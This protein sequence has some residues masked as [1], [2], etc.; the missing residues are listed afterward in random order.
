MNQ[1]QTFENELFKVFVKSENGQ[2]TFDVEQV[3][4]SLGLTQ[5][6]NGRQYIRWERVNEYLPQNSPLVGKGDF[7]PE[8]LV[9]KLAFKASNDV[10]EK[11][12]DWLAIEVI[13]SIRKHG[14]YATPETIENIISDPEFG[15]K[16]LTN[17]KDEKD[18]RLKAEQTIELQKPKVIYAEAVSVSNDTVLIKDL[19]TVLKQKGFDIG[20]NRLFDWLRDNGY[21]CKKK[22]ELW[23][24][25]TQRS[26]DL[27][28]MVTKHGLRTGSD[29][30]M[31][32]TR[33]PKIT[34]KGQIYFI[35]KF[36]NQQAVI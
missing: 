22:G 26:L 6:R 21:I 3:A 5:E 15:I 19:A 9:Y 27:G 23:N 20:A 25:P 24:T 31:K 35:K 17:L 11:F 18:K 1:L 29:G 33:T 32:K 4:K 2:N 16:L 14:A 28:I 30:E 34:G 36:M 13:P 7:I 12:Q 8:P 10:A